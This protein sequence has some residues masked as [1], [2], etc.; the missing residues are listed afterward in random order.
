MSVGE[1]KMASTWPFLRVTGLHR[2]QEGT[3]HPS[4]VCTWL[5]THLVGVDGSVGRGLLLQRTW[6]ASRGASGEDLQKWLGPD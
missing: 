5:L 6:R 2:G 4:M 3:C 1:V